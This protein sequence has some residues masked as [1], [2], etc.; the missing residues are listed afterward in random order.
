MWVVSV[1][2]A[3]ENIFFVCFLWIIS[4]HTL[5][6]SR[7]EAP[8]TQTVIKQCF[9]STS[10]IHFPDG[11]CHCDLLTTACVGFPTHSPK[12]EVRA[13]GDIFYALLCP[14]TRQF[15]GKQPSLGTYRLGTFAL[16][17]ANLGRLGWIALP[18]DE[19]A[20]DFT[21]DEV[22]EEEKIQ[23]G[24]FYCTLPC[25]PLSSRSCPFLNASYMCQAQFQKLD[26]Y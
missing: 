14:Q 23:A 4:N 25:S 13:D 26:K 1:F 21:V 7:A 5:P 15:L 24:Q 2:E 16:N 11:C 22:P 18:I 6:F 19:R 20:V 17:Q 3:K 10:A 8:S 9:L 12:N